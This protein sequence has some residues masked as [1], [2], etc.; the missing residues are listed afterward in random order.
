MP[1]IK[2]VIGGDGRWVARVEADVQVACAV[3]C[4]LN[5]CRREMGGAGAEGF[6]GF[7]R[8]GWVFSGVHFLALSSLCGSEGGGVRSLP[9]GEG[10][11]LETSM[12]WGS[13]SGWTGLGAGGGAVVGLWFCGTA[14][15]GI[16]KRTALVG[17]LGVGCEV[18]VVRQTV[19][20]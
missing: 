7:V 9:C 19:C 3:G 4:R 10:G 12:S 8:G 2:G 1:E 16:L 20:T 13:G 18:G 11:L 6:I 5:G 17:R 15:L 14:T